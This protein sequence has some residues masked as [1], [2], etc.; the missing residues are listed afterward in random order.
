MSL[1]LAATIFAAVIVVRVSPLTMPHASMLACAADCAVAAAGPLTLPNPLQLVFLFAVCVVKHFSDPCDSPRAVVLTCACTLTLALLSCFAV[2]LDVYATSLNITSAQTVRALYHGA[3]VHAR[4]VTR[5]WR[6]SPDPGVALRAVIYGF[7]V[8][9]VCVVIPFNY[10]YVEEDYGDADTPLCEKLANAGKHTV[11]FVVG[12]AL[13]A[14]VGLALRPGHADWR[15]EE[16]KAKWVREL[17]D[18]SH[19]GQSAL[20]FVTACIIALGSMGWVFYVVRLL[21]MLLRASAAPPECPRAP[22]Q[23]YGIVTLPVSL[24]RG[25]KGMG[26]AR[27]QVETDLIKVRERVREL[28]GK[29]RKR[30]RELVELARLQKQERCVAAARA[31]AHAVAVGN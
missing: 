6:L 11:Y 16:S 29:P 12:V 31:R 3:R 9:W 4:A 28:Q 22:A 26:D 15:A 23:G 2:P 17:F 1:A 20:L 25:G 19:A 7:V 27:S 13:L 30:R 8:L 24:I 5:P 18:V 21:L 14:L 10:F